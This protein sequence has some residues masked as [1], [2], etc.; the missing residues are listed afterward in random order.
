MWATIALAQLI[1]SAIH[2]AFVSEEG[3]GSLHAQ[4]E[5]FR[6]VL[7][8]DLAYEQ[9]ADMYAQTICY[10]LFAA[11][12]NA[13][14]NVT[15]TREH[16]V[17]DIPKTNPFL[18]KMF[19]YIAGPDLDERIVW[20][21]DDLAELLNRANM[22]AILKDFG[23][24][25]RQEDP[26][27]HFY[28]TFLAKYDP[29]LRELRG[30]FYTP[31]PVVSYMVRS[32]DYLL[33]KD[34]GLIDGLADDTM[35][36]V[37]TSDDKFDLRTHKV[38][39]LDPATGTATFLHSI[40]DLMHESFTGNEGMWSGYVSEHLL[41]RL[42][43][44]ELLMAPYTVAHMKLGV[45]L[46]ETGYDFRSK[47]RLRVYLTNTL[48][49]EFEVG[50]MLF[51][52][53]LVEEAN[54]AG[55]VKY[56][57]P[58][59]VVIGNPPYSGHSANKGKWISGLLHD[60]TG[61]YFEVDG[62]PLKER[63]PKWLNDDY[64][65][66]IRF[67]QWRIE[68][69]G[70]GILAFITNH[71]YLDN[72]TFRG[73]RQSLLQSFDEI[74]ILDLHGNSKKKEHSPDGTKDENVFDIQQGVAIG[75]FV[76][77]QGKFGASQ[78]TIVHHAHMWGLREVSETTPQEHQ[79]VGGKYQ[80]LTEHD[81]TTTNWTILTPE[82]PF[83]LFIPQDIDLRAEYEQGTKVTEIMP[84][85]VLGFQSHR[86]HFAIAFES[87]TLDKRI[88]EMRDTYI[89]DQEYEGKYNLV[90]NRDWK[91]AKARQMVRADRAWQSHIKHCLYRPFDWRF[92]Y[93]SEIA[94][95]YPRTEL[96][97]HML[98][99]NMSLNVPR[100]T[101]ADRW[102][103]GLVA[104][105]PTPAIYTEI[106]DGS[107]AFPLYLYPNPQ[108]KAL[109]DLNESSDALGNR[110]PNLSSL[111]ITAFSKKLKMRFI[112]DGKGDLVGTFGPEDIFHYMY[113]V[114]Y[115]PTYRTRYTEFLKIDF[116]RLPLTSNTDLFRELC[117]HGSRLVGL[118][119]MEEYGQLIL[120]YPVTGNNVV[121]K[122]DYTQPRDKPEQS[123]VWIN[124]TQYFEGVPPEVKDRKGRAL[125]F[126]EIRH[127]QR[128]VAALAET[129]NLMEE[130]D[131]TIEMGGGWPI[132]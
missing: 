72:P 52:E 9:F 125:S 116:P 64:V 73:M 36:K 127:Y 67:A 3:G 112:Q 48:E 31:E 12:C 71:S 10:G 89:S 46:A 42:F 130:I 108:K 106:K 129:I 99:P 132:V 98:H 75:V 55:N 124:K 102:R 111:F 32:V 35:L 87:A 131:E 58:V 1:R 101:K 70:Y 95:D 33:K 13:K 45:Q 17:Y 29:K 57:A 8:P 26:V 63:N 7:L 38:Q 40:I 118:H 80:W 59:M 128:I 50:E 22:D 122:V 15:F 113:A 56:D 126:D 109:F 27:V 104:N 25:T 76:K 86:D 107:N 47:E 16:A 96:Q 23:K 4:M 123:C 84:V 115:S 60:K 93:F 14:P 5:G 121:E 24:R 83:Y 79:L 114:F 19:G 37:T 20:A 6:Q 82:S 41:P 97:Q 66:F 92:C 53:W 103:H 65:K 49:E 105:T 44:F 100:Q 91:L 88:A 120:K 34:F 94:M 90:D 51:A 69:T 18:R 81:L 68:R 85:N 78:T 28:E 110:R 77:R 43:G 11:R 119:L 39:I 54:A 62:Q 74:Y 117:K 61:N 21:V 30:V 2:L